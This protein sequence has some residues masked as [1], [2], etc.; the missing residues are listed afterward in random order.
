MNMWWMRAWRWA[1]LHSWQR[2]AL[3]GAAALLLVLN[4]PLF[5]IILGF[6][7]A[8][9]VAGTDIVIPWPVSFIAYLGSGIAAVRLADKKGLY[10]GSPR[11]Q[12]CRHALAM[13]ELRKLRRREAYALRLGT[14]HQATRRSATRFQAPMVWAKYF[15]P[16]TATLPIKIVLSNRLRTAWRRSAADAQN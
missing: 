5:N 8:G 9:S 4:T 13:K 16:I 11:I 14:K 6:L 1:A 3:L 10:P 12:R 2:N 15:R 7:L